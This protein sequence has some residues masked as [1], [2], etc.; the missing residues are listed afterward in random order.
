MLY[1]TIYKL[2]IREKKKN[3]AFSKILNLEYREFEEFHKK[4]QILI[5]GVL[6]KYLSY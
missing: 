4:N 3:K 5:F 2:K 6:L 1:F